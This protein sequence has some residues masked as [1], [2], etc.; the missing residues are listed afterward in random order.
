M[1]KQPFYN[2]LSMQY[3]KLDGLFLYSFSKRER[4]VLGITTIMR[5]SVKTG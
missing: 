5:G 3:R 2:V 4:V 1:Q